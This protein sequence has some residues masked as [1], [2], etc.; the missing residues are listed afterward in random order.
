MRT[1]T[2][3]GAVSLDQ[4]HAVGAFDRVH[5]ELQYQPLGG[6]LDRRWR[7]HFAP[8]RPEGGKGALI[9]MDGDRFRRL[10]INPNKADDGAEIDNAVD[11]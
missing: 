4:P 2:Y 8:G 1:V 7:A 10:G 3:G 9:D 6:V 11:A 5:I